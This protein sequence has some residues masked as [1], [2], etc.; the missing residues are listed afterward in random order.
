MDTSTPPPPDLA[1]VTLGVLVLALLVGGSLWI[2]KPFLGAILWASMVVVATW[3]TL[4]R[5]QTR[6]GGRRWLAITIMTVIMLLVLVVPIVLAVGAVIGNAD[7]VSRWVREAADLPVPPPPQWIEHIPIVGRTLTRQWQ[8][9]AGRENLAVQLAPYARAVAQ[10]VAARIGDF[11]LLLLQFLL[12][13]I[14]TAGL[15]ATGE[16]AARSVRRFAR[17]LAGDR[18]D[19]AVVLAGQA[20]RAVALGIVV[21]AVVQSV[22]SG[23][24]LFVCGVPYALIFT[25]MVFVLCIVQLG[26]F[27]VMIPAVVWL[28]LSGQTLWASVLLVWTLL[29]GTLDNVLRPILIRRGADL[30]LPLII[31]GAIGGLVGFGIIGL[32][33]G[34]VVL[35]VTYRLLEWWIADIDPEPAVKV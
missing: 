13:V 10:W 15:Y 21:T 27:F 7:E 31:A 28:Y 34:P 8:E 6:L 4:I 29:V 22:V 32:F 1:R 26:P 11:G 30:P 24:G 2:L 14:V 12:T 5:L 35:A 18:G 20:I 25:A 3:P 17:R 16:S 19:Q 23:I 33:V 9:I